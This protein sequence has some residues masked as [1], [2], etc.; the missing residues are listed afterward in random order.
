[1]KMLWRGGTVLDNAIKLP[2]Y[3]YRDKDRQGQTRYRFRRK[4]LPSAQ[5]K[6]EPNTA[7]FRERYNAL[8]GDD[9]TPVPKQNSFEW[10]VKEY[11]VHLNK[12]VIA[13]H[14]KIAT[15][16][17][18]RLQLTQISNDHGHRGAF[19]I[20]PKAVRAIISKLAATPAKANNVL[21]SIRAIYTWA[22]N[23]G[24]L[25][26]NPTTGVKAI[27]YKTDGWIP[28]SM[29][30]LRQFIHVYPQ[31]TLEYLCVIL[32]LCTGGR[33][34]DIA[35]I[36]AKNIATI[37]GVRCI[38]FSQQKT[39]RLVI[40]PIFPILQ[41]AIDAIEICNPQAFII[42]AYGKPFTKESLGVWFAK[43]VKKSG[44]I[45][46]SL[47]GLRKSQGD[48]LAEMGCTQ[49]EIMAIQG[50]ADPKS[51]EIY[52]RNAE[53]TKL[54]INAVIKIGDFKV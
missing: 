40:V 28:W 29:P 52:T 10:L 45:N 51:S 9:A 31:G 43:K 34:G 18:R 22:I 2:P 37:N 50:H 4:G 25:D 42:S 30:E 16:K 47:H 48:L 53:R 26:D 27:Q 1:M 23:S 49:Y 54:A 12:Q 39:G 3:V 21:K 15:L 24:M 6:H 11:L 8:M 13:G 41:S 44:L 36:G 7:A 38:R 35:R 46:R 5:I 20:T 33:R 19:E 17:Q 32:T 14:A